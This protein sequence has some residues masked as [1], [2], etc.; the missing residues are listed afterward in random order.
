MA[1]RLF[2]SPSLFQEFMDKPFNRGEQPLS[3]YLERF[4][5]LVK[6]IANQYL[7]LA[8]K[9]AYSFEDLAQIGYE[10][11]QR[12]YGRFDP[13]RKRR[14][15]SSGSIGHFFSYAKQAIT[16]SIEREVFAAVGLPSNY[17]ARREPDI[18][19]IVQLSLE[20]LVEEGITP[21]QLIDNSSLE[22]EIIKQETNQ[23][24]LEIILE[25]LYTLNSAERFIVER[26]LSGVSLED[27]ESDFQREHSE[28]AKIVFRQ[29]V[30]KIRRAVRKRRKNQ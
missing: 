24:Q 3:F 9:A 25:S 7:D 15:R 13:D 28:S 14:N 2:E 12:A 8:E 4:K 20:G 27:I 11:L 22:E 18:A 17:R 19:P 5:A 1:K 16:R 23:E 30:S 26:M 10:A 6:S 21:Y 29:A